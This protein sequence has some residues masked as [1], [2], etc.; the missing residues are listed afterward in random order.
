MLGVRLLVKRAPRSLSHNNVRHIVY[1]RQIV[2]PHASYNCNKNYEFENFE[3]ASKPV[4]FK[5][6][7]NLKFPY[8]DCEIVT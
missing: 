7:N 6:H 2:L 8:T 1:I 4:L 5:T 3:H